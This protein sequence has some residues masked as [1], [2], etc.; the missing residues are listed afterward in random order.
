MELENYKDTYDIFGKA[1]LTMLI[2]NSIKTIKG[3]SSSKVFE[4]KINLQKAEKQLA[5]LSRTKTQS[6]EPK[7]PDSPIFHRK[8]VSFFREE[9][10]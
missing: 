2:T 3:E 8:K 10:E 4:P 1:D 6:L 5:L 9:A 7:V